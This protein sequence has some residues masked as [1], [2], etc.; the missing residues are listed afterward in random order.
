V[1]H[2]CSIRSIAFDL[3]GSTGL[4]TLELK[5]LW[6]TSIKLKINLMNLFKCVF[7]VNVHFRF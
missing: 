6:H 2:P 7:G 3:S 5:V 4:Q 1:T